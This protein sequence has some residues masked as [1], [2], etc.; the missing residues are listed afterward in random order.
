MSACRVL[1]RGEEIANVVSHGLALLA[2][3]VVGPIVLAAVAERGSPTEILGVAVFVATVVLVYLASTLYHA[4]P[5]GR[6][7]DACRT[8]DHV[9]IYLLIAGTYTPF[10]L[11]VL[12]GPW[13]WTLLSLIWAMAIGG[14]AVT[15]VARFGGV[16]EQRSGLLRAG[17]YVAMGWLIVIAAHE[18]WTR[19]PTAGLLWMAAGGLA[20]TA[21]VGFYLAH[22]LRYTHL[23]WHLFVIAGT[24]CHYGAVVNYAAG[25]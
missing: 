21:G 23:V 19:V 2:A 15:L 8:L 16:R 25:S 11:G 6:A 9:A 5:L 20:Y 24:A 14:I 7:K 17:F 13:G 12:R 18:V 3:I 4:M 22:G 10:T 1:T